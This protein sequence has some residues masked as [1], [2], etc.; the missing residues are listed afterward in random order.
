[1]Q[2]QFFSQLDSIS[3]GEPRVEGW[4]PGADAAPQVAFRAQVVAHQDEQPDLQ[5]AARILVAGENAQQQ[6]RQERQQQ[7]QRFTD[8]GTV[9]K[10]G[11]VLPNSAA[12]TPTHQQQQELA[13]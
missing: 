8:E 5:V 9:I 4:L 6:E 10:H 2:T 13:G 1:M 3:T 12:N 7:T 11:Q